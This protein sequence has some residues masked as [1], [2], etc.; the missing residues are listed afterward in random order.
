MLESRD[1]SGTERKKE[2]NKQRIV[3]EGGERI[4]LI[5]TTQPFIEGENIDLQQL[6]VDVGEKCV[7]KTGM[8]NSICI[9][10][11]FAPKKTVN[12]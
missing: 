8:Q 10:S 11:T 7:F 4:E 2:N 9:I 1:S 12:C 5:K 6:Y 3:D